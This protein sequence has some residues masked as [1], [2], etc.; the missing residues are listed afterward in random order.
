MEQ[1]RRR[2]HA[3]D[4]AEEATRSIAPA[5]IELSA[6]DMKRTPCVKSSFCDASS[7]ELNHASPKVRSNSS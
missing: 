2:E 1:G 4:D 6:L 5:D 3:A 7:N